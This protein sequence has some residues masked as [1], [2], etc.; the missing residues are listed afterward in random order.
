MF[1]SVYQWVL[2]CLSFALTTFENLLNATGTMNFYVTGFFF[3]FA[4][5]AFFAPLMFHQFSGA[6]D[7]VQPSKSDWAKTRRHLKAAK[8]DNY[9]NDERFEDFA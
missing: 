7:G 2:S 8:E 4:V 5:S 3:M 1:E 6:S 9:I